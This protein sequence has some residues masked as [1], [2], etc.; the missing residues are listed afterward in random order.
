MSVLDVEGKKENPR[1][2]TTVRQKMLS[3]VDIS[4]TW[5]VNLELQ[6]FL[7]G[8]APPWQPG[9]SFMALLTV[10]KES[11]LTKTGNSAL[12]TSVFH[13]LAGNFCLCTCLL[14]ATR[15]SS[16]TQLAQEFDACKISGER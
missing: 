5:D 16:L 12:T 13:K 3:E 1:R 10:S 2:M 14:H 6:R 9:P 11:T 7:T 15:Q 8:T 4:P